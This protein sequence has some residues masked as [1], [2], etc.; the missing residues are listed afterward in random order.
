MYSFV[1]FLLKFVFRTYTESLLGIIR[2]AGLVRLKTDQ[3]IVHQGE[4]GSW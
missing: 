1:W 4:V 2:Q 3:I